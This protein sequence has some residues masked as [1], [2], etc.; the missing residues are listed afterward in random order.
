MAA[1]VL[2]PYPLIVLGFGGAPDVR[3]T[4]SFRPFNSVEAGVVRVVTNRRPR[5]QRERELRR[6]FIGEN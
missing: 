5:P 4:L 6:G 3:K 1:V 2:R